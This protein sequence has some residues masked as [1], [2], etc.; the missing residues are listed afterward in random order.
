[1]L[2]E[3]KVTK[4]KI[5]KDSQSPVQYLKTYIPDIRVYAFALLVLLGLAPFWTPITNCKPNAKLTCELRGV[6]RRGSKSG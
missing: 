5:S 3:I 6:K 2:Q 1:M 4:T